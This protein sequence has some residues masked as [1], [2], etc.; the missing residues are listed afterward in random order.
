MVIQHLPIWTYGHGDGGR[1]EGMSRDTQ[2]SIVQ[3]K[4]HQALVSILE[5]LLLEAKAGQMVGFTFAAQYTQMGVCT[6]HHLPE[7]EANV[8]S[9]VGA[10]EYRKNKIIKKLVIIP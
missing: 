7:G 5:G 1:D 9:M 4:V 8:F 3:P 10:L 6:G 2:L